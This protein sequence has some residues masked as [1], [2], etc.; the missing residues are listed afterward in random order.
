MKCS[1][2]KDLLSNYI[3]G[4]CSEET[5]TEVKKHL[6]NCVDCRHVYEKMAD[7]N[8]QEP[9]RE[10]QNDTIKTAFLHNKVIAAIS[11]CILVL[12]G[13]FIF[14]KSYHIPL[15]FDPND[16]SVNIY[17]A[18]VI[19]DKGGYSYLKSLDRLGDMIPED[20]GN[21]IDAVE[22]VYQGINNMSG[23]VIDRTV[24]R[25]GEN[26]KVYYYRYSESLWDVLFADPSLKTGG[27]YMT[28]NANGFNRADFEPQMREI[29][30]LPVKDLNKLEKFPDG[31]FD[32][33][34]EQG[35]LILSGIS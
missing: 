22:L 14:A 8:P 34:R 28:I 25:D 7:G 24:S 10:A 23:D 2:I 16:M 18:A 35:T 21:V 11:I 27:L 5:N 26:V 13:L 19:T 20:S 9:P 15:P 30:Y 4:R 1:I 3:D 32:G 29:Y 12:G 33:L 17:K 31:E 6:D